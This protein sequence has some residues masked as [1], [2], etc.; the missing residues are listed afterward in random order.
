MPDISKFKPRG[1]EAQR[2]L[3]D[4]SILEVYQTFA[5][6]C[7]RCFNMDITKHMTPYFTVITLRQVRAFVQCYGRDDAKAIVS[8]LFGVSHEGR[9]RGEIVGKDIFSA[10][11]RWMADKL[12]LEHG[13]SN[14]EERNGTEESYIPDPEKL[15]R[16]KASV[17]T[18]TS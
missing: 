3:H 14:G 6:G 13:Q 17:R 11:K 9:W 1:A 5:D 18:L 7:M 4:E 2:L 8:T 10:R 16:V 12:L 15:A